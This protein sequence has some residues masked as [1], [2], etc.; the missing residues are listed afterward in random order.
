MVEEGTGIL[1]RNVLLNRMIPYLFLFLILFALCC[2]FPYTADDWAVASHPI[3]FQI[4]SYNGRYLSHFLEQFFT[5]SIWFRSFFIAASI[6]LLC[7]FS[8]QQ[9]VTENFDNVLFSLILLF[10]MPKQMFAQTIVWACGF[11]AFFLSTLLTIFYLWLIRASFL[12]KKPDF[13]KWL[14]IPAAGIGFFSAFFVENVTILNCFVGIGIVW[15]MLVRFHK[16]F[17]P[18]LAYLAGVLLGAVLMFGNPAYR[19]V[20]D[21]GFNQYSMDLT[22]LETIWQK[23]SDNYSNIIMKDLFLQNWALTLTISIFCGFILLS[24]FKNG[25]SKWK[26]RIAVIFFIGIVSFPFYSLAKLV[27]PSWEIFFEKTLLFECIFSIIWFTGLWLFV[28]LAV[29]NSAKRWK[30]SFDLSC[31]LAA[32]VPLLVVSPLSTR[33]VL[34]GYILFIV[35]A[36]DLADIAIVE[37]KSPA[38][39]KVIRLSLSTCVGFLLF[40]YFSI[41]SVI[42]HYDKERSKYVINKALRG[43]DIIAV[44]RLPYEEYLFGSVPDVPFYKSSFAGYLGIS[45]DINF[46]VVSFT[47]WLSYFEQ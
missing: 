44:S 47:E 10:L 14:I 35:F 37:R 32:I 43:N 12:D 23:I 21:G 4:P 41:Y 3:S 5:H 30:L 38:E 25:I 8:V 16:F 11:I 7:R 28:L 17:M 46:N 26:C 29:S 20:S 24:V 13:P 6:V 33:C 36:T 42:N 18:H 27:F 40:F 34:P 22:S 2:L 45:D 31:I 9:N 19:Q 1:M 15:M 39:K